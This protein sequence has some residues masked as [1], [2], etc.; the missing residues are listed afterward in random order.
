MNRQGRARSPLRAVRLQFYGGQG[1]RLEASLRYAPHV[2]PTPFGDRD[3]AGTGW[4]PYPV[5]SAD[6]F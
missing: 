3:Y 5:D 1:I 4:P 6:S 2:V